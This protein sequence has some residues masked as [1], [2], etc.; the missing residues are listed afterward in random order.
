MFRSV[1]DDNVNSGNGDVAILVRQECFP[2]GADDNPLQE[3]SELARSAGADV[4]ERFVTVRSRPVAA[5]YIGKGKAEE[6]A[7]LVEF[8]DATL[9][10]LDH[11]ISPGQERNLER[12]TKCRVLDRSGLILDIFAQRATS[13]EGKLQVELAQLK[14]LST[15]LVRG[16]THLDREKGGIGLRGPGESQLE[17]DRRLI[18][19]RIKLLSQRLQRVE[20]QRQLR[21]RARHRTPI[22]TVSLVGYTNA[23]KSSIFREITG[24]QVL[25]EDK[26]FA[27]LDPTMRRVDLPGFGAVVLSDTV[28]FV[29]DL[30]HS[31][32]AAFHSTLEEVCSATCLLLV[33]DV[34]DPEYRELRVQ[35]E[36]VLRDI[37]AEDLPVIQV[38]NKIDLSG[39]DPHVSY[40]DDGLIDRVW[41]SAEKGL[42][43]DQLLGAISGLLGKDHRIH[44]ISLKPQA[45]ALRSSLFSRCEVLDEEV[46]ETGC[47]TLMV[48]MD[49]ATLGWLKS[50]SQYEGLWQET[51]SNDSSLE[52]PAA[53]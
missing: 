23:G 20:S 19:K 14:H 43:V 51:V 18:G 7:E 38:F 53:L 36:S 12:A 44:C 50:Q 1:E 47:M 31:L 3:L 24:E 40:D 52:S 35:V 49:E 45:G 25:V 32:V 22:P 6:L 29:R 4:C 2:P 42:G 37:G 16:W 5:T 28:G 17:T 46:D 33:S 9:I 13:S 21:R 10:I 34:S 39:D 15:R 8:Y 48:K 41:L 27:T 26:L 30:P 11:A